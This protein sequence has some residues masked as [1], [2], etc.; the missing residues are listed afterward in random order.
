ML[1]LPFDHKVRQIQLI[2]SFGLTALDHYSY[3]EDQQRG[4]RTCIIMVGQIILRSLRRTLQ[5]EHLSVLN[6]CC[7]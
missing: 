2:P 3:Y 4:P 6:Q 1:S 5:L 7:I